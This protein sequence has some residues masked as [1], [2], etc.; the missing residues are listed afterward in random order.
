MYEGFSDY[1]EFVDSISDGFTIA[2]NERRP[3]TVDL[4]SN[5]DGWGLLS[6]LFSEPLTSRAIR[7]VTGEQVLTLRTEL[8]EERGWNLTADDI[9]DCLRHAL[10]Q[11]V[12]VS[13]LDCD[14]PATP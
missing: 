6:I 9:L 14:R 12:G 5:A 7:E 8:M 1:D 3:A 13:Q 4:L 11:S 10:R 2:L